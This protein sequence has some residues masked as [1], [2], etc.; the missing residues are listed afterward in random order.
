MEIQNKKLHQLVKAINNKDWAKASDIDNNMDESEIEH[1]RD[2]TVYRIG[3]ALL[4]YQQNNEQISEKVIESAL[5]DQVTSINEPEILEYYSDTNL[6][7]VYIGSLLAK[8]DSMDREGETE[9][10]FYLLTDDVLYG[11]HPTDHIIKARFAPLYNKEIVLMHKLDDIETFEGIKSLQDN[12]IELSEAVKN[13][14]QDSDGNEDFEAK[15]FSSMKE[16]EIKKDTVVFE[17]DIHINCDFDA[18]YIAKIY[19][20]ELKNIKKWIFKKN[21]SIKG[22]LVESFYALEVKGDTNITG[23][24]SGYDASLL[25]RGNITVD[26]YILTSGVNQTG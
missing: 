9:E 23:N 6:F 21:L 2:K 7:N 4:Y 19:F 10:A 3:L 15:G 24:I 14:I 11:C 25:F 5:H 20:P 16:Y 22:N 17:N 13:I 18:Y 26:G 12:G 8:A 1:Y